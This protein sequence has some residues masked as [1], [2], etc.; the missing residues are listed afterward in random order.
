MFQ[1]LTTEWQ[2]SA[3]DVRSLKAG[4]TFELA[5]VVVEDPV[6]PTDRLEGVATVWAEAGVEWAAGGVW[7]GGAGGLGAG[8]GGAGAVIV[9]LQVT[10]TGQTHS[11][12]ELALTVV[13][14]VVVTTDRSVDRRT[15][16]TG[17]LHHVSW[18]GGAGG[19]G[20]AVEPG[21]HTLRVALP[22]V[23]HYHGLA[24]SASLLQHKSDSFQNKIFFL[25]LIPRLAARP[26]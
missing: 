15:G 19:Q 8:L 11:S 5:E 1:I 10:V 24:L 18:A 6:V 21:A 17:A 9:Q 26:C 14:L 20:V 2:W 7:G 25:P 12:V 22:A 23:N 4:L 3:R 16:G 13:C